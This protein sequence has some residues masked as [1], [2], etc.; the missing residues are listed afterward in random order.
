MQNH[1]LQNGL[2]ESTKKLRSPS[3]KDR[4]AQYCFIRPIIKGCKANGISGFTHQ[5]FQALFSKPMAFINSSYSFSSLH[6]G[7]Y[8]VYFRIIVVTTSNK[9]DAT[10]PHV[11]RT[12]RYIGTIVRQHCQTMPMATLNASRLKCLLRTTSGYR[13]YAS[14]AIGFHHP[15]GRTR[16]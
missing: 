11:P 8:Q 16:I 14:S 10:N 12:T 1:P 2:S 9:A 5:H 7:P 6:K 15:H 4:T 3:N 13:A